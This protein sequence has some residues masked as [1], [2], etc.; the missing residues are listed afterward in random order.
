MKSRFFLM[1]AIPLLLVNLAH[2]ADTPGPVAQAPWLHEGLVISYTWM[3]AIVPGND[4]S[5]KED[6]AGNW[7]DANGNK[8][9]ETDVHGT[10]GGGISQ[11]TV[12]CIDKNKIVGA[13][14]GFGDVR[15]DGLPDPLPLQNGASF[16][17]D[18]GQDSENWID[19]AHLAAAKSDGANGILVEP[20]AWKTADGAQ[21]DAIRIARVGADGYVD[22]IYDKT[23]GL[24]LHY[25]ISNKS[26]PT[27]QPMPAGQQNQGDTTLTQGDFLSLRDMKVPWAHED[28]PA[29][30]AQFK[31][32]HF[33]GMVTF[34]DSV[35]PNVPNQITLDLT[36][37]DHG[38]GWMSVNSVL[39]QEYQGM[40]PLPAA[41]GLI[42]SGRSQFGGLWAGPK[43]LATL[44]RGDVLDQDPLTKMNTIVTEIDGKT[45]TITASNRT[46]EIVNQYD[47]Q[48]GMII[49]T[50]MYSVVTH[51][52]WAVTL[53]GKE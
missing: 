36:P 47:L 6:P 50:S 4:Q 26:A 53:Q 19:P 44:K 16:I 43:A 13:T 48:T 35:L 38:D 40:Q 30:A 15:A 8:F 23:T 21:H 25:A 32:L 45:I 33:R 39:Q 49:G 20:L 22:H 3:Q 29:W 11:I 12:T 31:A 46:G 28:V 37:A 14:Q 9:K 24:C 34:R 17:S 42:F 51:Q 5:F 27:P 41:K 10:S 52:N 7:M 1:A 18:V 2:G